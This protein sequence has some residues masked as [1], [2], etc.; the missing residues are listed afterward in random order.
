MNK[1]LCALAFLFC[2]SISSYAVEAPENTLE[3]W[4]SG[5]LKGE[6]NEHPPISLS[7]LAGYE[8]NEPIL[9]FKLTNISNRDVTID[10]TFLPWTHIH[11]ISL[12]AFSP[13]GRRLTNIY[14]I[15]DPFGSTTHLLR[16]GDSLEGNYRLLEVIIFDKRAKKEET[17]VLWEYRMWDY[18]KNK[19]GK[20]PILA[21]AVV[22]PAIQKK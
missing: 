14:P 18:P 9:K 21:G 12:A 6:Q 4:A 1:W 7:A 22:F 3:I 8:N 19:A 10:E 2:I 5:Y 13:R 11:N 16:P 20:L 15:D 17:I